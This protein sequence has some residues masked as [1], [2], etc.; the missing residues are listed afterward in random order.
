MITKIV[1]GGQ[2]GVDR[3]ALDIALELAIPC[4][5]W[6]PKGRNAEDGVIPDKDPL[7]ETNSRG[8]RVRTEKNVRDSGGTLILYKEKLEGVACSLLTSLK[9]TGSPI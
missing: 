7:M 4:G 5:G 9:S 2:T 1:S 8:Y 6:C 3:A